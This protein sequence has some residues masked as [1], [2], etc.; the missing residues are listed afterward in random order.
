[1]LKK[2]RHILLYR[3]YQHALPTLQKFGKRLQIAVVGL[4]GQ[5]AQPLF[6][7][8]IRLVVLQEPEVV[9]NAHTFDYPRRMM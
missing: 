4:A 9:F 2:R 5:R 7:A 3:R 6:H 1:M 8:K